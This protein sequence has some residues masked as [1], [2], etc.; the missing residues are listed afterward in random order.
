MSG[1]G[2]AEPTTVDDVTDDFA[3]TQ[4]AVTPAQ[5]ASDLGPLARIAREAGPRNTG[6]MVAEAKRIGLQMGRGSFYSFPAGG[7]KI[8]G[9][10]IGLAYALLALWGRSVARVLVVDQ[11][12]NRVTLRG[13]A[14]DLLNVVIIERDYTFTMAPPPAKFAQKLDQ[15]D[16]WNTMQMQ[17]AASKAVRG[18]ILSLLP[19][20]LV[21]AAVDAAQNA[22]SASVLRKADGSMGTV[23]ECRD[24]LVGVLAAAGL[25]NA[26]IEALAGHPFALWTVAELDA[27]MRIRNEVARGERTVETLRAGIKRTESARV[28][29]AATIP[30]GDA[31]RDGGEE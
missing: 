29:P 1:F 24:W 30:G 19:E 7:S 16:R 23:A 9:A 14:I 11:V 28:A 4:I 20:W 27:M 31:V 6:S 8:E 3:E 17:S 18:V 5:T 26:E 15:A 25:T 2:Y 21:D 22:A 12:G 13:Q 10:T